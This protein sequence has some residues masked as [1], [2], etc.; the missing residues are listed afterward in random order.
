[1]D[2][3]ESAS[4]VVDG[5]ESAP[6]SEEELRTLRDNGHNVLNCPGSP[7]HRCL[8]TGGCWHAYCKE[9]HTQCVEGEHFTQKGLYFCRFCSAGDDQRG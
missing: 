4:N 7:S 5:G 2:E 6:Y 9:S 3:G 1:M 8:V